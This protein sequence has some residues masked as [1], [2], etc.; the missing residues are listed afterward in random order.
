MSVPV[1]LDFVPPDEPDLARLVIYEATSK[2][3]PWTE[4][5]TVTNVGEQGNYITEYTTALANSSSDWF[6]IEWFDSKDAS[7]GQ[8][9]GVQCG[10][11]G[12]VAEIVDRVMLRDPSV[13][14]NV[15]A[16]EAEAVVEQYMGTND[17]LSVPTSDATARQLSGLTLLTLV[18]AKLFTIS[19]SNSTGYTAGLVSQTGGSASTSFDTLERLMEEANELLGTSFSVIMQLE[20]IEVAGG[21]VTPGIPDQS[22]LLVDIL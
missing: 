8:S 10:V 17:P 19:T 22:R 20:E 16:Q 9:Q 5:E 1:H 4:I 12:L 21:S 13:N 18:R 15:V 3:G 7:F 2:D 6:S 14:E 11:Q